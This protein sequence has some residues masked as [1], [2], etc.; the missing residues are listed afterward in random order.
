VGVLALQGRKKKKCVGQWRC[1]V[2]GVGVV[3]DFGTVLYKKCRDDCHRKKAIMS[4]WL[5]FI[6]K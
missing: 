5:S 2:L 3:I 6:L 4:L 1:V